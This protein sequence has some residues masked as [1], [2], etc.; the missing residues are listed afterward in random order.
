MGGKM[1][2]GGDAAS[3]SKEEGKERRQAIPSGTGAVSRQEAIE[4]HVRT[5][6]NLKKLGPDMLKQIGLF[7]SIE[8][9]QTAELELSKPTGKLRFFQ[10][11]INEFSV[12]NDVITGN[13]ESLI[14]AVR[15][16]PELLF[17][18]SDSITDPAGQIFY[19][20]CPY[21][22]MLFLCDDDMLNQVMRVVSPLPEQLGKQMKLIQAGLHQG[23]ADLIKLDRDPQV[24]NF[25]DI[26]RFRTSY[27]MFDGT[28]KEVTFPLLENP[29]GVLYYKD[30]HNQ[31][32]WYRANQATRTIEPIELAPRLTLQQQEAYI[33]L[34]TSMNAMEPMSARRSS[35]DEHQFIVNNMRYLDDVKTK[36]MTPVTL[37]RQGITY[38]Q[39]G[40]RYR[41]TRHDF[42]RHTNAYRKCIRLYEQSLWADGDRVWQ[43]ELGHAQKEVMWLLQRYCEENRPFFPLSVHYKTEPFRRGFKFVNWG[44]GSGRIGDIYSANTDL[45]RVGFGSNFGLYKGADPFAVGGGRRVWGGGCWRCAVDL[46]AVTRLVEDAKTNVVELLNSDLTQ[47]GATLR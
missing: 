35:N 3:E 17:I 9:M 46:V 29:D 28:I 26:L 11:T 39:D 4:K 2:N 25:E 47:R 13:L 12:L 30:E 19:K 36:A 1:S 21:Q 8:E 6:K 33:N 18:L 32:H 14:D 34:V 5:Q 7:L 45:F 27:T 41:D 22:M 44:D 15:G 10:S 38:I 23:G 42:N 43:R 16:N 37:V 40:T 31:D 20:V 24:L